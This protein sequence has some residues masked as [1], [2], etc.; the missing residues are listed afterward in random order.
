[1]KRIIM[2]SGDSNNLVTV[3]Q[4]GLVG[5]VDETFTVAGADAV[6]SICLEKPGFVNLIVSSWSTGTHLVLKCSGISGTVTDTFVGSGENYSMFSDGDIA[7]KTSGSKLLTRYQ[8]FSSTIRTT[9]SYTTKG[10]DLSP[11]D[12][13]IISDDEIYQGFVSPNSVYRFALSDES[14]AGSNVS[15]PYPAGVAWSG[16]DL[17][18]AEYGTKLITKYQGFS[19]SIDTTFLHS[20]PDLN[21]GMCIQTPVTPVQSRVGS[22]YIPGMIN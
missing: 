12:L 6:V 17:I 5:T 2:G 11:R 21:N 14:W 16:E 9:W 18:V 1:M 8:G 3:F 10:I 19:S 15:T 4:D 20:G 13:D 22:Y 7:R